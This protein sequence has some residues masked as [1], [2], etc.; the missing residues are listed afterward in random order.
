MPVNIETEEQSG[1]TILHLAGDLDGSDNRSLLRRVESLL[2]AGRTRI[3]L[4]MAKVAFVNSSGLRDLVDVAART[5]AAKGRVVLCAL[6]GFV[7]GVLETTQL[8]RF[9]DVSP[10]LDAAATRATE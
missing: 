1:L 9:F 4:Y 8:N 10:D 7:E 6:T 3:V 2:E 5:N